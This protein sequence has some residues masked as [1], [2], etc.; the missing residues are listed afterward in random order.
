MARERQEYTPEEERSINGIADQLAAGGQ[1]AIE[2]AQDTTRYCAQLMVQY[3]ESPK[4]ID[5]MS[6]IVKMSREAIKR[7]ENKIKEEDKDR[8]SVLL[9]KRE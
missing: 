2:H 9:S 5:R 4:I 1:D 3:D 7:A 8:V 6:K